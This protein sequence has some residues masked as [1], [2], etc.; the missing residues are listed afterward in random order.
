MVVDSGATWSMAPATDD[1]RQKP[2]RT[3]LFKTASGSVVKTY[4]Y[5]EIEFDIGLGRIFK[6]KFFMA[7][8]QDILLGFDFLAK[9]HIYV[10]CAGNK[11]IDTRRFHELNGS[12]C[13]VSAVLSVEDMHN[14]FSPLLQ[15]YPDRHHPQETSQNVLPTPNWR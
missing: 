5:R 1:D 14:P 3:D 9:H 7:D 4:D 8:V 10:D 11:V 2:V 15:Q 12:T 13:R 6:H